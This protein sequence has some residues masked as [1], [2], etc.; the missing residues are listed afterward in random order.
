MIKDRTGMNLHVGQLVDIPLNGMYT[1]EVVAIDDAPQIHLV[2]Q[3]QPRPKSIA[4][5]FGLMLPVNDR[6]VC[7]MMYIVKPAPAD[8]PKPAD[9]T[10]PVPND[11]V[12]V[13]DEPILS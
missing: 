12:P 5:Q 3:Q 4:V 11:Y 7:P 13:P 10:E 6:N 8:K 1:A 2:G 9:Q